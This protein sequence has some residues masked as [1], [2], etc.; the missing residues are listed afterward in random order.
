MIHGIGSDII[1][2]P[3]IKHVLDKHSMR[4]VNRILSENEC[5]IYNNLHPSQQCSFLAKRFA[6]KE[7]VA[8]AL[9]TG[10]GPILAFSDI[11][12]LNN[13]LGKPIVNIIN[14]HNI[15]VQ[16]SKITEYKI[17]VSISDDYPIVI[18]FAI[19]Y[20]SKVSYKTEYSTLLSNKNIA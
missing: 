19:V 11:E 3:R 14:A 1:H 4:F 15:M 9:G 10:I 13:S 20:S 17:D 16:H 12:V 7:S 5:A 18:A 8:K 6:A 2:I